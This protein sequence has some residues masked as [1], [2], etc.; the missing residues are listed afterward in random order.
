MAVVNLYKREVS[1]FLKKC[2]GRDTLLPMT[3]ASFHAL[4][5]GIVQGLT[6]FLPISSSAHLILIPSYLGWEDPGLAFDVALH[7]GTLAG[8]LIYF[9]KD[10]VH[11]ATNLDQPKERNTVIYLIVATIPGA[12]AGLLL[13]HK[14]ETVFRSPALIAG[15]LIAMGTLLGVADW[16]AKGNKTISDLNIGSAIGLGLSQGFALIPGVSRSGVTI[17]TA[18]GL[19]LERREAAK[20]SFLMSIPIIAGAGVLKSKAIMHSPDK[21]A[22]GVGFLAATVAGL[23]AIWLLFKIIETKRYIPFVVYRWALGIFVL[24]NLSHFAS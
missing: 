11:L 4:V 14:V 16:L 5:L 23:F 9:W 3:P 17:T 2:I 8:V 21:V 20:F 22:L 19:G 10:L 13:E 12:L 7:L 15:V 18:L 1:V 24:L 6:E